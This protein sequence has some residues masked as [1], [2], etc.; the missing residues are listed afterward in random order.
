M[1][2]TGMSISA[3]HSDILWN[4]SN[5]KPSV[6]LTDNI[7]ASRKYIWFSGKGIS[8][9]CA[10]ETSSEAITDNSVKKILQ[11]RQINR[12]RRLRTTYLKECNT[13]VGFL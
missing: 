8:T 12:F 2:W 5:Y 9:C 11:K 13:M 6:C 3:K 4:H 1:M 7:N 10:L